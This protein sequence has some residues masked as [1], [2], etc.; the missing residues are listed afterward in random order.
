[1]ASGGVSRSELLAIEMAAVGSWPALQT[2]EVDGWLWRYSSG[3][4]LR[5]NSVAALRFSGSSAERTI[6]E[7]ERRYQA[8]GAP[9]RF[10]VSE[11]SMPGNLDAS[12]AARG[13]ARGED[14]VTMA[15]RIASRAVSPAAVEVGRTPTREWREIYMGGLTPDRSG[16]AERLLANLPLDR[17]FFAARVDGRL[18]SSGLSVAD[19]PLASVQCMATRA[20]SLRQGGA[21]AVL[22]AIEAWAGG[23]GCAM[24][25]LQASGDN[26]A[27]RTLYKRHGF[28]HAGNYHIRS[29]AA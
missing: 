21:L 24:L 5:A 12:L 18:I 28:A 2:A 16:A 29:R 7:V 25:Y 6:D 20:D 3:G 23:R 15:K 19:G 10:T 11:V 26:V 13:Y 4:S 17:M 1:M 8:V 9:S 22:S 14:H 27:A